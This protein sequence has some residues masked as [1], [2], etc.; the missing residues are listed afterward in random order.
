MSKLRDFLENKGHIL[1]TVFI[2]IQAIIFF[3]FTSLL[4]VANDSKPIEYNIFL[5]GSD[6]LFLCFMVHFAYHSVYKI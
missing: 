1:M 3:I 5:C 6:F 2:I 4:F